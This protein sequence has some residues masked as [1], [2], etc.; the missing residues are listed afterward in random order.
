V[1]LVATLI[2]FVGFMVSRWVSRWLARAPVRQIE[3]VVG[4]AYDTDMNAA[5]A[6]IRSRSEHLEDAVDGAIGAAMAYTDCN[7]PV[8]PIVPGS[9]GLK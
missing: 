8:D 9:G 7:H 5:V 3:V 1:V 6:A 4:V 2:L